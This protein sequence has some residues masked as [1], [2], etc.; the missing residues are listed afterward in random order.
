[1]DWFRNNS[2]SYLLPTSERGMQCHHRRPRPGSI[3]PRSGEDVS[4]G[5]TSSP[6]A[7]EDSIVVQPLALVYFTQAP[8]HAQSFPTSTPS[9]REYFAQHPPT[10]P[11]YTSMPP[12]TL[13]HLV[14]SIIPTFYSK[15]THAT[16]YKH[17]SIVS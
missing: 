2:K 9:L 4:G 6:P 12:A 17:P 10:I 1:M 14:S 13:T 11:Y 5:S 16:P 3:N 8:K 7:T 15:T